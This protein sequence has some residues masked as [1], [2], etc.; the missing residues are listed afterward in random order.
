MKF[1]PLLLA[2][3]VSAAVAAPPVEDEEIGYL[4]DEIS[5]SGCQFIRNGEAHDAEAGAAH[6]QMK[7]RRARRHVADAE[8]F[9]ERIA[10]G[11]TWSG[12]PYWVACNGEVQVTSANWLNR[13]LDRHRQAG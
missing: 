4:L 6:L 13:V 2:F 11:S 8:Q 5:S 1:H 9:I 7:Y 12:K 10:T 3:A